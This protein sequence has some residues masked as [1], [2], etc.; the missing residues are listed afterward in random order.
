MFNISAAYTMSQINSLG[1]EWRNFLQLGND[2]AFLTDFYQPLDA[3]QEYFIN[4]YLSYKQYNLTL[5]SDSQELITGFRV[6]EFQLGL[7]AGR[8]LGHWGRV[9]MGLYYN[10]G[11]NG[12]RLGLPSPYEGNFNNSGFALRLQADTLDSIA[13]PTKGYMANVRYRGA[14]TALGADEDY[15][16]LLLEGHKAWTWGKSTLIPR[17]YL[18]GTLSGDPGPEDLFLLGGFLNLSGYQQGDIAG[19]NV[20]FGELIYMYRLDSASSAFSIPLYAGGSLEVGGVWDTLKNIETDSIIPAGSLFLGADTPLGPFY[21]G[22]GLSNNSHAS[23]YMM[24]GKLF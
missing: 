8:N 22:A 18:G 12:R 3:D 9:V 17:L 11:N 14:L 4:P 6:R 1:A 20:A 16:T 21:L 7:D 19:Q 13:F 5:G 2:S 10:G 23:L 24:L 15:Q